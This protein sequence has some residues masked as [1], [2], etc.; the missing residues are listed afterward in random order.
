[1]LEVKTL[2]KKYGK[3]KILNDL[4]LT[5]DDGEL[6]GFVG[7]NGAG[8][9]TTFRI[10]AGLLSADGGEVCIGGIDA[11]REPRKIK[12]HIGY[13]PDFFGVYDN[14]KAIEYMEFYASIYN[15]H[16]KQAK[17]LCI[18]LMELV[19]L[20]NKADSYVDSLSRGMKQRLCLA[21]CMIH[22]PGLLILD[23]PASGLDPQA[24]YEMKEILK[25]LKELGKTIIIS[26]HILTEL[27]QMCSS[28]GII[29]QG[30]MVRCDTVENISSSMN[31]RETLMI[32][33]SGGME[34]ALRLIREYPQSNDVSVKGGAISLS[35]ENDVDA[36]AKLLRDL[37]QAGVNV[38]EFQRQKGDLEE[39]FIELMQEGE[40]YENKPHD[41]QGTD[42]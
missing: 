3:N 36:Q 7:S 29:K 13:M 2:N 4:T 19:N 37:V 24:R 30:Q 21:R 33:V 25:N 8:K 32:S 18:D 14:L 41:I 12:R 27:T 5:V 31:S 17:K 42:G 22:N 38:Y 26:S 11:I 39:L 28:I 35:F 9:T 1:M 15:I 23:E 34:E 16:G 10:I 6:F 40:A 20:G